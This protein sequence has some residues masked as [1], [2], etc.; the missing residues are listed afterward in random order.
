MRSKVKLSFDHA[1]IID[2]ARRALQH[3]L[4]DPARESPFGMVPARFTM[5]ELQRV[6]EAVLGRSIG[7]RSFRARLVAEGI[8]EPVSRAGERKRD[9][10]NPRTRLYRFKASKSA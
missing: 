5:T 9:G 7:P 3:R 6:Y 8:V 1:K 4:V 10:K 2:V